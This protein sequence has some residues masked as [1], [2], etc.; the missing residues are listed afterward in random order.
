MA[1]TR[2]TAIAF[3]SSAALAMVF[4]ST[5]A[6]A[7]GTDSDHDGIPDN[8][9]D[10][11]QRTVA[12]TARGDEFSVSSHL[13]SGGLEDDFE[14]SY[15]AG[16]FDVWYSHGEGASS[17]YQL[18]L[19]NLVAWNDHNGNGQIDD[20]EILQT[21][22]LGS[23]AFG[24]V[25]VVAT[26]HSDPDGGRVYEFA[27]PSRNSNLTLKMTIARRF[28]FLDNSVLTP[29]EARV[30][31]S[32]KPGLVP[33]AASVGLEW[34]METDARLHFVDRSWDEENHWAPS[35]RSVNVTAGDRDHSATV[36][37]SWANTA[38]AGSSAIPVA[39]TNATASYGSVGL[40]FA[41]PSGSTAPTTSI[42]HHTTLGVLSTV[43]EIR[44]AA[45]PE[46]RGDLPLFVGSSIAVAGIVGTTIFF[47]N[48][49][50][51]RRDDSGRKP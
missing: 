38:I 2:A 33:S 31:I 15:Q 28:M 51:Q 26:N 49:R 9:E 40:Y 7:D 23:A 37:F 24:D 8:L 35:E 21:T 50:R 1:F 17:S 20:G 47:A 16:R 25:P 19:L 29:M 27:I 14:L 10:A 13:G 30:D 12:A 39:L 44:R 18:E 6:V 41:Y 48:R 45:T 4:A 3:A 36:F 42:V 32:M 46:I 11:T 22:P 43:F 5:L 34:R